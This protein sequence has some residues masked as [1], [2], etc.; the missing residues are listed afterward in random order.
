MKDEGRIMQEVAMFRERKRYPD[1][2]ALK[3][4]KAASLYMLG[5]G[6]QGNEDQKFCTPS[7]AHSNGA[8]FTVARIHHAL[9]A[10]ADTLPLLKIW[11]VMRPLHY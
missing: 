1:M 7:A 4:H 5:K 8:R 10:L 2:P 9:V 6:F 3:V 11:Y